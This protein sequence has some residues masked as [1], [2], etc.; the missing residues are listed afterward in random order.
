MQPLS[1]WGVHHCLGREILSYF[2]FT[3]EFIDTTPKCSY[4]FL[5]N[6]IC[7]LLNKSKVTSIPHPKFFTREKESI[8]MFLRGKEGYK[9]E[10]SIQ[11]LTACQGRGKTLGR[12]SEGLHPVSERVS[13]RNILKTFKKW[14]KQPCEENDIHLKGELQTHN[15]ELFAADD[16]VGQNARSNEHYT[17]FTGM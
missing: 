11:E 10:T 15:L 8:A 9:T 5:N 7:P 12:H 6:F 13:A 3:F 2:S 17:D 1:R 16:D 14:S 4:F